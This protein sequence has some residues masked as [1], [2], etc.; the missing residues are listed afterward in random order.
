MRRD[1]WQELCSYENLS[2]AFRKAR[3]H[4]TLKP[5]VIEFEKNLNDNLLSLRTELSI[6]SYRPKP[7]K[8]FIV[9]DPKTRKI[10]KSEFRDRIVH[11]ALCNI[12]EPIFEKYF[13]YGPYANSKGKGTLKALKRFDYFKRKI[14]KN[15]TRSCFVLKCDIKHYFQTVDPDILLRIIGTKIKDGRVNWLIKTILKNYGQKIGG[16]GQFW[17]AFG[18]PYVPIFCECLSKRAGLFC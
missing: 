7:L 18:K 16:G 9:R 6:H 10:S 15:N 11:H 12:I 14:S 1:L 5:Y 8:S 4:K 3:R 17:N 2:V 13:I